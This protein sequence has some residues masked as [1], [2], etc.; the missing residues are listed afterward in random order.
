MSGSVK[1]VETIML[2]PHINPCPK[3]GTSLASSDPRVICHR[4]VGAKFKPM[5]PN[6]R[7]M[8]VVQGTTISDPWIL[9][10]ILRKHKSMH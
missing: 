2:I 6:A 10:S 7:Y 3:Y 8:G 4:A 5:R 1:S 9:T